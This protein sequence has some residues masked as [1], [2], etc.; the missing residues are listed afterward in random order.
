MFVTGRTVE[1]LGDLFLDTATALEALKLR[2]EDPKVRAA[3]H[4]Y[5]AGDIPACMLDHGPSFYLPRHLATPS[6]ETLYLIR[7]SQKHGA[8]LLIG[9]DTKGKFV[10][11]NRIKSPWAS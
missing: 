7:F 11:G 3:V 10:T 5:L 4:D 8:R 2:Q 9:Q 1:K 6:N